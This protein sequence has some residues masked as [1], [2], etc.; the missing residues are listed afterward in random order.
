MNF[1]EQLGNSDKKSE[2]FYGNG[3]IQERSF[4]NKNGKLNGV[5]SKWYSNGQLAEE[6]YYQDGV[7]E[8]SEIWYLNGTLCSKDF[9][10]NGRF[11]GERRWWYSTGQIRLEQFWNNGNIEG[12]EKHYYDNGRLFDHG[13][14]TN[15]NREG[16]FRSWHKDGHILKKAFYRNNK[17]EGLHKRWCKN[18]AMSCR[19]YMNGCRKNLAIGNQRVISKYKRNL[20]KSRYLNLLNSFLISDLSGT[21]FSISNHQK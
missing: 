8:I 3:Q 20:S 16:A 19:F 15:G 10:K 18:G 9:F 17:K 6:Q 1:E 21:I 13:I 12:V 4:R 5:R 2:W 14:Y 7:L 11:H